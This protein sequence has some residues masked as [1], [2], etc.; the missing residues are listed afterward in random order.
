MAGFPAGCLVE[1]TRVFPHRMRRDAGGDNL[2]HSGLQQG[3]DSGCWGAISPAGNQRI[4]PIWGVPSGGMSGTLA[5]PPEK[6]KP[7]P[8]KP[9]PIGNIW[10][11]P[12]VGGKGEARRGAAGS[13]G[14]SSAIIHAGE[15]WCHRNQDCFGAISLAPASALLR[16]RVLFP[17]PGW[18]R[19]SAPGL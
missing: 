5:S 11:A 14:I 7:L 3:R 9:E 10:T 12:R 1:G 17:L 16:H 19:K 8:G 15:D 2:A 6:G 13:P 4:S 18:R